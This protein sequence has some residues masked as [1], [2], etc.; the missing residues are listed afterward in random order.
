VPIETEAAVLCLQS[1]ARVFLEH[2]ETEIVRTEGGYTPGSAGERVLMSSY[3]PYPG[4]NREDWVDR[5]A[6]LATMPL[7]EVWE[8]WASDRDERHRDPDGLELTRAW[9]I[10]D[11]RKG[12]YR[13]GL[14][15][16][17]AQRG[18]WQLGNSFSALV[19]WMPLLQPQDGALG[20]LVQHAEDLIG[21]YEPVPEA[22]RPRPRHD[23][24]RLPE[25]LAIGRVC[26][27]DRYVPLI[28]SRDPKELRI[29]L[30]ALKMVAMERGIPGCERGPTIEEFC[31][32]YDAG[33]FNEHDF[34]MLLLKERQLDKESRRNIHNRF[35]PIA[36]VTGSRAHELLV[37]RPE[38]SA[39][40][41]QVRARL[42]ELELARGEQPIAASAP[43]TLLGFVGGADALLRIVA[44]LGKAKIVGQ[45]QFGEPSRAYSLSRLISAT[46]PIDED[47]DERFADLVKQHNIKTARL[48]E[49]GMHAPQWAGYIERAT[50]Q[51]GFEDA[52]WWVRAHTR[53]LPWCCPCEKCKARRTRVS[54]HME[55]HARELDKGAVDV[56][57]FRRLIGRIGEDAW[58]VYEKPARYASTLGDHKRV[59][60][61]AGVMLGRVSREEL[62]ER[63]DSKRDKDA[64]RALG[65]V[66]LPESEDDA[67]REALLVY[68]RLQDFLL[69]SRKGGDQ[70]QENEGQVVEIALQNLA[71]NAGYSDPQRLRWAMEREAV[72]DLAEGPVT[73]QVAETAVSLS[74]DAD[75][76]PQVTITKKGRALKDVPAKLR[77]NPD[78]SELTDRVADLRRQNSRMRLSLEESMCRGD[79]FSGSELQDFMAHPMLRPM[80]ERLVFVG[81]NDSSS[82]LCGYPARDGRVLRGCSAAE[83]PIGSK[84]AIRIAHQLDL[85]RRGDWHE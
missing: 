46:K 42:F 39:K 8:R 28:D 74:I 81:A 54:E 53:G 72:A 75:G 32:A 62:I 43:S 25:S 59:L 57:W 48:L 44:A 31:A 60:M 37:D 18:N 51:S 15:K 35:G 36:S 11:D 66:R 77:T 2:A 80:V 67:R 78:I 47:T 71:R 34:V 6:V 23:Y 12:R 30:A 41:E 9:A 84:D 13:E 4:L 14:P 63:I 56:G 52:V 70:R 83:E 58:S 16:E 5:E 82:S 68:T 17:F 50:A 27:F 29:R 49:V 33:L 76:T 19:Q 45:H 3:F 24:D 1:L 65:L 64:V 79:V 85:F 38:L 55:V 69:E 7:R 26:S 73:V 21:A 10:A 61:L 20:V 22:D 40:A